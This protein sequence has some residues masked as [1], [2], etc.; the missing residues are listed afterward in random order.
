[1]YYSISHDFLKNYS[2]G[3]IFGCE[4]LGG[5][6]WGQLDI[7]EVIYAIE[8]AVDSG[9]KIFD[10]ADCYGKGQ[11]EER[12]GKVLQPYR[13]QV[14]IASKYSVRFSSNGVYYDSSPEWA[15]EALHASLKR[16]GTDYIDLFQMHYWDQKTNFEDVISQMEKF[17]EAGKIRS[18]GFTNV[19]KLPSK[20]HGNS[21]FQT[22]SLEYSLANRSNELAA[23]DFNSR[24]FTFFSYGSLGQ[25]VL[26]G[27][28]GKLSKF[29]DEDRRS[30]PEY[31]NFHG[32]N[33]ESNLKIVEVINKWSKYLDIP[34]PRLA[35]SWIRKAIPNSVPI[36][37]IKSTNQLEGVLGLKD[38]DLPNEAFNEFD[39][40]SS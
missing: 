15:T 34:V 21:N 24:N 30:R 38:F 5:F 17:I 12:L 31:K 11:S 9:V 37:G 40:I 26:S 22:M 35:L 36:V 29:S 6:K 20:L 2:A 16:L 14:A 7:N 13:S 25:G 33:Y 32:Q 27:K 28:Y 8:Q 19:K 10:T 4:Q 1:M 39:M 3:I 18:Y 23:K